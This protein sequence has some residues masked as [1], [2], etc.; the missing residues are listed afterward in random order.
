M[1]PGQWAHARRPFATVVKTLGTEKAKGTLAYD[2]LKQISA[3]F[4]LEKELAKLSAEERLRQRQLILAPLVEA[5]FEWVKTNKDAVPS[6]SETGKG[7]TY[8]LNQEKYLREF[9]TNGNVPMDNNA[10]EGTIR[11][12]CIGRKNWR[13]IDTVAG[14]KSSAIIYSI[15]ETAKAN[16]LKPY[17][18]F[19]FLLEEIPKHMNEKSLDFL[20]DLL[21]WSS[22]LPNKCHKP[23]PIKEQMKCR[24]QWWHFQ[25]AWTHVE[26]FTPIAAAPAVTNIP[27][28]GNPIGVDSDGIEW[29]AVTKPI[30]EKI[31]SDILME[32]ALV[33]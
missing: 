28:Y 10:T 33:N 20:K 25:Y 5:F 3:L 31:S 24:Q 29:K 13:L 12:F 30:Y 18:Y 9:L 6:K 7:F 23:K 8:C 1:E 26:A 32:D 11:G 21:P 14:A 17:E 2:A 19:E 4:K 16:D 27:V 22:K 15:A